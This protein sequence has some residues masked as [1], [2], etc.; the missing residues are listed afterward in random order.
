M[1]FCYIICIFVN[2]GTCTWDY[3]TVD[4]FEHVY[5]QQ[6]I[7]QSMFLSM[8]IYK[9]KKKKKK[10]NKNKKTNNRK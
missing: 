8:F 3:C 2:N 1:K 6:K 9:K 7:V 4:V 5:L 10:K